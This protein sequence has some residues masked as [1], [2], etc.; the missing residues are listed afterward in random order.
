MTA[1]NEE[2]PAVQSEA[3]ENTSTPSE[4]QE[5][6]ETQTTAA[7]EYSATDVGAAMQRLFSE[8]DAC[9]EG[10]IV[11]LNPEDPFFQEILPVRVKP[12]GEM[13]APEVGELVSL[14]P[15]FDAA[16]RR[17]EQPADDWWAAAEADV[18]E[19]VRQH[20][21][22]TPNAAIRL[23]EFLAISHGTYIVAAEREVDGVRVF[24]LINLAEQKRRDRAER[25]EYLNAH[26]EILAAKPDWATKVSVDAFDEDGADVIYDR[27]FGRVELSRGA[28]FESGRVTFD[29]NT[30]APS[31]FIY[32]R[33]DLTVEGMRELASALLAAIPTVEAAQL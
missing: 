4:E 33:E 20:W 25:D 21:K 18:P 19:R 29:D 10:H 27:D 32:E 12:A 30:T 1:N 16:G 11:T 6:N 31:V 7:P 23:G 28:R 3:F 22:H 14:A 2:G 8:I 9:P 17:V 13:Q 26:P 24:E 15:L 5:T